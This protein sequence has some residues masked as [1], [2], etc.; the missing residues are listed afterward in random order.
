MGL[1]NKLEGCW[2]LGWEDLGCSIPNYV[3]LLSLYGS[4][5]CESDGQITLFCLINHLVGYN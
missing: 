2:V 3:S 5:Q 4:L 1:F